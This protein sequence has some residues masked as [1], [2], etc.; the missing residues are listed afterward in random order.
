M[1]FLRFSAFYEFFNL[2]FCVQVNQNQAQFGVVLFSDESAV[3]IR[4]SDHTNR[5]DII[6]AVNQVGDQV[7][8][9]L[10]SVS[11]IGTTMK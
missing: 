6:R 1:R 11:H 9:E 3:R 5:R 7:D 2:I 8:N 10:E 4:F